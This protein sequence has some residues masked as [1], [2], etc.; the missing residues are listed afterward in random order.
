M[1]SD[2]TD[3]ARDALDRLERDLADIGHR[4][5]GVRA[6]LN[7]LRVALEHRSDGPVAPAEPSPAPPPWRPPSS[8]P[9]PSGPMPAGGAVGPP[10]PPAWH[11]QQAAP[12][13]P[14]PAFAPP[15]IGGAGP[16]PAGGAGPAG[17][18]GRA[19]SPPG[20]AGLGTARL[21][22][23]AGGTVT[24]LGVVLL[25]VLAANRGWFGPEARVVGGAVLGAVLVGIGMRVQRR[26][27]GGPA[28]A[29]ADPGA[30][31]GAVAL[32]GTGVAALFLTD[33]AATSLNDL[34]PVAV[35]LVLALL[36]VGGGLLLADRW[37]SRGL[38]L[39]VVLGGDVLVPIV[40]GSPTPLLVGFL[41]VAQAAVV[42][43]DARRGWSAPG[44]AAGVAS[45][46]GALAAA[47]LFTAYG[48]QPVATVVVVTLVLL[49]GVV[50]ATLDAGRGPGPDRGGP[51]T[52]IGALVAGPLVA[53]LVLAPALP[54]VGG[55]V[56]ALVLAATLAVASLVVARRVLPPAVRPEVLAGALVAVLAATGSVLAVEG[57]IIALRG[58]VQGGALLAEALVL[59]VLAARTARRGV[60]IAS[61]AFATVGVLVALFRDLP[62]ALLASPGPVRPGSSTGALGV[63]R[64]ELLGALPVGLLVLGVAVALLVAASRT[65][66]LRGHE[67]TAVIAGLLGLVGLYGATGVLVTAA[68]LVSP[69]RSGFLTGHVLVTVS[70]TVLALVLLMRGVRVPLLR[71]LGGALVIAALV[72]LV[73]FDLTALDGVPRVLAFLGAGIVLLVAG[74]RYARLVA[75]AGGETAPREPRSGGTRPG[76]TLRP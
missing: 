60:L 12:R 76:G 50:A 71:V 55:S 1:S 74:T 10:F 28:G 16:V 17:G 51:V 49:A 8:R 34:L 32:V 48:A 37:R 40:V 47:V 6:G 45:A 44:L 33:A 59:A 73:L 7:D 63:S 69:T 53:V 62:L 24:L 72:K 43:V 64:P 2:D 19:A 20:R 67:P 4:V 52:R 39:G 15:M 18:V 31:S 75:Q 36:V 54:R 3:L 27:A 23:I 29:G 30:D 41:L 65:G 5:D 57:T 35:A 61:G 26:A 42:G 21:L 25:L 22:G 70:W 9:P 66:L 56:L 46:V 13:A 11:P 38:A 68:L 14:F 58:A